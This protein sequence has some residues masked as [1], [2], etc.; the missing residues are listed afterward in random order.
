MKHEPIEKD[1]CCKHEHSTATHVHTSYGCKHEHE[2]HGHDGCCEHEHTHHNHDE[3]HC[4]QKH[5]HEHTCHDL[6]DCCCGHHH[7]AN[8]GHDHHEHDGCCEHGHQTGHKHHEHSCGCGHD[9][10]EQGCCAHDHDSCGCGCGHNHD[11]AGD[12][13]EIRALAARLGVGLLLLIV[14]LVLGGLVPGWLTTILFATSYL[15]IG[16]PVLQETVEHLPR[17]HIFDENLLMTVA[18]IGAFLLGDH[19]EAVLVVALY[20]IGELLQ[21]LAV[22]KSKKS[23]AETMNIRPDHANLL[24]ETGEAHEVAPE[25]VPVG[26]RILIHPGDRIPLD[27][28]VTEGISALDTAALTGE[29]LPREVAPGDVLLSGSINLQG[30]LTAQTTQSFAD[31][32]VQRI[33]KLTQ[34]SAARKSSAEKFITRFARVYTPVVFALAALLT[35]VPP[36]LRLGAWDDWLYRGLVFLVVSCPCALVI[37]VPVGFLAGMG[38]AARHGVLLKG[39]AVLDHLCGAASVVF[40]KTGT[41][42]SGTFAVAEVIPAEDADETEL[43]ACAALCE[44]DSTHPIARSV[45]TYC[46]G[47]TAPAERDEVLELAGMGIVVTAAG[48]RYLAGPLRLMQHYGIAPPALVEDT[49]AG[50]LLYLAR[51]DRFLG[52]MLITDTMKPGV[53]AAL[54]ALRHAG[55]HKLMLLSGDRKAA[56][57]KLAGELK[58]DA[59]RAE[60]LPQDKIAAFESLC[61]GEGPHIYVGDGINDAPLLARADVGIAMGGIGS[62]AAVEAADCVLMRD[63]IGGVALALRCAR[64]TRS[65]VRQNIIFA[66]AAKGAVLIAAAFGYAPMWLAIFADV[67]VA[68]LCVLN[69]TRAIA[70]K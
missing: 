52:T 3:C 7:E 46:T 15:I 42:T 6:D 43:L 34:E 25:E 40:D 37:S 53:P 26:S 27:C 57:A 13:D 56:V 49:A 18:S 16:W 65:I 29:S 61:S 22:A 45:M 66:L 30:M 20:Q 64:R 48:S 10:H 39:G 21:G 12:A 1:P 35:V 5:E 50:T 63:D 2:P 58:L 36:L 31:S 14:A 44:A 67:G 4:E 17:G 59:W 41:L 19:A 33:L 38:G 70:V 62:D 47:K 24:D 54:N 11:H 23:I 8:H 68:L 60:L 28:I 32:T 55:V 69:A 51:D 9:H